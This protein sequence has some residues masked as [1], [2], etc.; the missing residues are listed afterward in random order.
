MN[1]LNAVRLGAGQRLEPIPSA[2]DEIGWL[3][4]SLSRAEKLLTSRTAEL[5]TAMDVAT[6]ATKAKNSFLSSTS[7]ELRT[8]LNSILGFTQL[9]EMSELDSEDADS[10]TR[11]LVPG[12]IC[13]R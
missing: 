4:D 7:H 8:P 11:I 5:T 12:A 10:V 9:L 13:S 2:G 1:A 6:S 3:S